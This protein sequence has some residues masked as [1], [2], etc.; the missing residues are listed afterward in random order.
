MTN[1]RILVEALSVE[2]AGDQ[3]KARISES[4]NWSA[5]FGAA[6]LLTGG[7]SFFRRAVLRA[8]AGMDKP[9]TGRVVLE[10]EDRRIDLARSEM[11]LGWLPAPGEEVFVGATVDEELAFSR[12][13][14]D[15]GEAC[16]YN[17]DFAVDR[18]GDRMKQSVWDLSASERR[19]LLL[20]A[21]AGNHPGLW[22]CLEPLARL[23]GKMVSVV[24]GSLREHVKLGAAVIIAAEDPAPLADL[25]DKLVV[26]DDD[27][28]LRGEYDLHQTT[29][30]STRT[31]GL[32]DFPVYL[33]ASRILNAEPADPVLDDLNEFIRLSTKRRK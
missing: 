27:C 19:L 9:V 5:S 25:V 22:L 1:R 11:L 8:L 29:T 23:D 7:C 6:T 28:H 24:L 13:A 10:E 15:A 16:K 3:S 18:F 12:P 33:A 14:P 31:E 26:F 20:A 17:S 21:Q 4:L 30:G 32:E 2:I